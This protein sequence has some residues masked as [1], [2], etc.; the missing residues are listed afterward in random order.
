MLVLRKRIGVS[1][2]DFDESPDLELPLATDT[3]VAELR[4]QGWI[5]KWY[6][7]AE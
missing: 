6:K 1:E 7:K 4:R 5:V 3:R 2:S